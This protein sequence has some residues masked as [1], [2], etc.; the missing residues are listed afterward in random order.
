MK[1]HLF[2]L[3]TFISFCFVLAGL[4]GNLYFLPVSVP[5]FWFIIF[6]FYSFK[7]PLLFSLVCNLLLALTITSFSAISISLLIGL[8]NIFTFAFV[9]IRERFHTSN[10]HIVVASGSG[11]LLFLFLKW[12]IQCFS[13]G[14]YYPNIVNWIV[15]AIF[16]T[17]LAPIFIAILSKL[18][19]KIHFER[20]DTLQNLRV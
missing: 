14:F 3:V 2:S 15:S 16:T 18:D 10:F 12:F 13:Q 7:K 1:K 19:E 20:I 17:L 9:V 11:Y 8:L 6:S 4:Q 5:S